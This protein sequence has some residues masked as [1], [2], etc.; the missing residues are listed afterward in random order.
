MFT[1]DEV[2]ASKDGLDSH[3]IQ[4]DRSSSEESG[5][6][7][8]SDD[9]PYRPRF[10]LPESCSVELPPTVK[11]TQAGA[12]SKYPSKLVHDI[13]HKFK[14]P[15]D[16]TLGKHECICAIL[17][18]TGIRLPKSEMSKLFRAGRKGS[19]GNGVNIEG[20][21]YILSQVQEPLLSIE[22]KWQIISGDQLLLSKE[23]WQRTLD[24]IY[25]LQKEHNAERVVS[26]NKLGDL[27]F[28]MMDTHGNGIASLD[29][30]KALLEPSPHTQA[31]PHM[32]H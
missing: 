25:G 13:F 1:E 29:G 8:E 31:N 28:N 24:Q 9:G 16:L 27:A 15:G 2:R 7:S 22:D 20:L 11:I 4:R 18:L 17:A 32:H 10:A 21:T 3:E 6:S 5:S 19:V 14:K 26:I 30:L 12:T 23:A